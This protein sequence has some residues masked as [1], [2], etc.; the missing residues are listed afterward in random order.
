MCF[1]LGLLRKY[2]FSS[3]IIYDFV[4]KNEIVYK[5]NGFQV[6]SIFS[7]VVQYEQYKDFYQ[8]YECF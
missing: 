5:N 7:I 8:L 1:V 2:I 4:I 6:F 3:I